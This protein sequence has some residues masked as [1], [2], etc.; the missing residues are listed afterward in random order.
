MIKLFAQGVKLEF[1]RRFCIR[2]FLSSFSKQD[3]PIYHCK[4]P[5]FLPLHFSEIFNTLCIR[6]V[7]SLSRM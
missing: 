1:E 6:V 2:R 7:S 3:K 5:A 4:F